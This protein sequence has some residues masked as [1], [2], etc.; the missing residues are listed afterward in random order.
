MQRSLAVEKNPYRWIN[1]NANKHTREF[2]I[3]T[4]L[5]F[6][7]RMLPIKSGFHKKNAANAVEPGVP[8]EKMQHSGQVKRPRNAAGKMLILPGKEG[9]VPSSS[10]IAK[11]LPHSSRGWLGRAGRA[12]GTQCHSYGTR[13]PPAGSRAPACPAASQ[14]APAVQG[15]G[16][17]APPAP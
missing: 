14:P 8:A 6:C 1:R 2:A 12:A 15:R 4:G 5:H 9:L 16:R 7:W 17:G 11:W 13:K 10:N 3:Q